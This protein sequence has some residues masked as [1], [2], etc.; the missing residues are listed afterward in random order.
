MEEQLLIRFLSK[1]C[2]PDE[3]MEV[4]EWISADKTHANWLFEIERLWSLKDEFRFSN[5]KDLEEAFSRFMSELEQKK[6]TSKNTIQ[7]ST[8]SETSIHD[9]TFEKI[10]SG[11]FTQESS[12]QGDAISGKV[13]Q[14]TING[15]ILPHHRIISWVKYAAAIFIIVLL[16]MNLYRLTAPQNGTTNTIEVPR[17]QRVALTLCDGTHVWLNSDSKLIYPSNFGSNKREVTLEGEGYF[18]VTKDQKHPFVVHNPNLDV[19]VL[20]TKFNVKA[21]HDENTTVFLKEG[22][23]EVSDPNRNRKMILHPNDKVLYSLN[24]GFKL[25]TNASSEESESWRQGELSFIEEP[26]EAIIKALERRYDVQIT[27]HPPALNNK[28]FTCRFKQDV[29][30]VEVL[31]L[32]KDTREFTY[33]IV[34]KKVDIYNRHP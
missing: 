33:K 27:V 19:K 12:H 23:V 7:D 25:K 15:T 24:D 16:S 2:T 14:K 5:K 13:D 28:Y 34:N 31:N 10:I 32:L 3:L 8:V 1:Q 21:Y 11:T 26:L 9:A 29:T 4:E 17:G 30:L 22:K 20:G 18:E 6:S